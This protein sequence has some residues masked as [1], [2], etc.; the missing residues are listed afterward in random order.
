MY[1]IVETI[2]NR[3][4]THSKMCQKNE[5]QEKLNFTEQQLKCITNQ[6]EIKIHQMVDD[7][8]DK[9]SLLYMVY[10]CIK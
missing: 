8:E 6:M 7:V 10:K 3:S 5:F 2:N 9:V 1:K 4:Q